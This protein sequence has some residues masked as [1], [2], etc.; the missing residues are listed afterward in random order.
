MIADDDPRLAVSFKPREHYTA[1]GHTKQTYTRKEAK[2]RARRMH[3]KTDAYRCSVCSHWHIGNKP[4]FTR[5][6]P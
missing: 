2:A 4:S 5:A 3:G 1:E 6:A